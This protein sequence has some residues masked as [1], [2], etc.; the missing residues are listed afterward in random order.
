LTSLDLR[1]YS[2][3][4]ALPKELGNLSSLT[5]LDLNWCSSMA[6]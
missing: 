5:T 3:L 1:K 6:A 2:R 4:A